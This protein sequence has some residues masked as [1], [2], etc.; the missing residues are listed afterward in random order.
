MKVEF[1]KDYSARTASGET[2]TV[3]TGAVLDLSPDKAARLISSG[4]VLDVESVPAIWKWFVTSADGL[5]QSS[6]ESITPEAWSI[7]KKHRQAAQDCF[8]N[9]RIA[10]AR[11]ELGKALAA[12]Q[13]VS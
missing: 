10:E 6:A 1:L 12:L 8:D 4:I 9:K 7:H 5:F 11:I 13:R 3:A 2:R